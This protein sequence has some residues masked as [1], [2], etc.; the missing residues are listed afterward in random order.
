VHKIHLIEDEPDICRLVE[1]NL[2]LEGYD[3][4]VS[5]AGDTGLKYVQE[6]PVDLLLLDL[7]LP[8]MS[9][10]TVCHHLKNSEKTRGIP[11]IMVT[12]R[13][14][15]DDVVTGLEMGADDY[16]AKPFSPRVLSARVKAA[17]RKTETDAAAANLEIQQFGPLMI[18]SGKH[19]VSLDNELIDLTQSEFRI[20]E[21]LVK[22]SGWVFTRTQLVDS[23]RGEKFAVTERTIDFQMVGLRKKLGEFGKLIETVRGV[24]YRFRA[25]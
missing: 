21:I 11:I 22:R 16:V 19:E 23:I 15:E 20:L 7:M 18:H 1:V 2:R 14:E 4:S 9:G 8:G 6:N 5:M 3:V 17:L 25:L 10:L 13:G 24:G 12:A